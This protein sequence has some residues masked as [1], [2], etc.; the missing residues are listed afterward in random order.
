MTKINNL[1]IVIPVFNEDKNVKILIEEI[2]ENLDQFNNFEL[3]IVNDGSTDETAKVIKNLK[4]KYHSIV[5][6]NN[7]KNE[8]QSKSLHTGILNSKYDNICTMDG[9]LQNDPKD[10][11]KIYEIYVNK[12]LSLVGGIRNKRKDSKIKIYASKI[13]NSIRSFLLN[14]KC[15]DTG[16]GLKI[17]KK[18][19]YIN[20]HFWWST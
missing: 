9:D 12:N 17:F 19:V 2:Y 15:K 16:C 7:K 18:D 10:I 5:L 1:S 3:L 8:G 14:D 4:K 6:I 11:I 20:I 13:A